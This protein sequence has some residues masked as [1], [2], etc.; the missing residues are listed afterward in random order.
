MTLA[1]LVAAT[2]MIVWP[3]ILILRWARVMPVTPE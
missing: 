2:T 1:L 3:S